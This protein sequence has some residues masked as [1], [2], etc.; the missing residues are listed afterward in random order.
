LQGLGLLPM[1]T[2]MD[3]SKVV[4]KRKVTFGGLPGRWARLAGAS[5]SGYEIRYGVT[6]ARDQAVDF[7]DVFANDTVLATPV[8][9]LLEDPE[10]LY[11]L[12]G[13]RPEPVLNRVFSELADAVAEHMDTDA[14][15]RLVEGA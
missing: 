5:A 14:L 6:N 13:Q 7:G 3:A 4:R 8:H 1:T 11:R 10:V 2:I 12:F 15:R 9:G